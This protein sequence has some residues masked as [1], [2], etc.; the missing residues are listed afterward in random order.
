MADTTDESRKGD[1]IRRF[2]PELG[3]YE[4]I[5]KDIHRHPELSTQE[6]RTAK[7]A[8]DHLEQLGYSV[9]R[10]IGGHGVVGV[11]NNGDGPSVLLRADMDALP[12][13]EK[14]SLPYASKA[15][16][17]DTDG[18]VK[19]VSHACGHDMHVTCLMA[20]A[21]LLRDARS[22]WNGR[23]ILAF[24]PNEERGHGART[25]VEHGLY[26]PKGISEPDVV[27]GQHVLNFRSGFVATKSGSCLAGKSTFEVVIYGKGGH[28]ATPHLCVDPVVIAAHI[29]IRLQTII[30]REIDPNKMVLITCGSIQAGDAPN[31]I[32]DQAVLKVDIR[33]YSPEVLQHAVSSFRRVVRAECEAS[34]VTQ[35]PSIIQI[36]DVP[37]LICDNDVVA[38]ITKE[39][40]KFFGKDHI[41]QMNPTS[42]SDDFSILALGRVPY[43]Y[44]GFGGADPK[45]WQEAH[46]QGRSDEL[47]GNH[48]PY[49]APIIKPTLETGTHTIALAALTFLAEGE[50][51]VQNPRH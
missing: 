28:G 33:A 8:A 9:R 26:G 30:S 4:E 32:P 10:G 38:A 21:E 7:I 39:F 2:S 45:K 23:L 42:A 43:A 5:Y 51:P 18:V 29:I 20:A 44:W 11:I 31:V 50:G 15:K 14:T 37:P 47:P 27:L 1:I 22:T 41:E 13:E 49:Y 34:G 36:E 46:D 24:Q 35:N 16:M 25:M 12:I 40:Q 3:P 19:P 17:K 6:S 48:S